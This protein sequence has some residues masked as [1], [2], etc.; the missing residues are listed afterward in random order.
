MR[1]KLLCV[2]LILVMALPV[3]A[4]APKHKQYLNPTSTRIDNEPRIDVN[5]ISMFVTNHGNYG[6]DLAG[7]FGLD[8]GTFF[9]YAGDEFIING[10]L[11]DWSM[12][13]MGMWAGGIIDG[14]IHLFINEYSDECVPGPTLDGYFQNDRAEFKVYKLYRD[15]L[16]GNPNADY[17]NWPVDQGAPLN[18][19]GEPDMIG[20][21]MLWAVYNDADTVQHDNDA[22][23]TDPLGYELRQTTFAF[24]RAG[25]LGNMIFVRFRIYNVGGNLVDPAYFSIWADPDL[26]D[27]GDDFVGCDTLTSMGYVYND[28]DDDSHYAPNPPAVGADFFQGPLVANTPADTADDGTP[29]FG[30]MWG[31]TIPGFHNLGMVSFSKY[32]NG[33]DPNSFGETYAFMQGQFKFEGLMTDYLIDG[34]PNEYMFPGDPV[35][36]E[37][38]LDFASA[39]RRWM[40]TTGPIA[41]APGDSTEILVAYIFGRGSSA[42]NSITVVRELDVF[43]QALYPEFTPPEPPAKPIVDVAELPGAITLTWTDA[44]QTN[45]GDY[46]FEGYSVWQGDAPVKGADWQLVATFDLVNGLTVLRDVLADPNSATGS[47]LEQTVR[48]GTDAGTAYSYTFTRNEL[49]GGD[50]FNFTEYFFKVSAF[51]YDGTAPDGDKFLESETIV[52]ATPRSEAAGVDYAHELGDMLEIAHS[53]GS[54]DGSVTAEIVDPSATTGQEYRVTFST[55]PTLGPVWHLTNVTTGA[56]ILAD[57]TNQTGDANYFAV[58]GM[59]VKVMGPAP[60]VKPGDMFASDDASTWGWDIVGTRRFTWGSA[61]GF[62]WEGFRG[63]LGW[64]GPGDV[65]GFGGAD[66]VDPALLPE[67]ELRLATVATDGTYDDTQEDVSFGYRYLRGA[68]NPAAQPEFAPFIID[69]TGSYTFQAFEKNVPLAAYNMDT[70]PPTR[71]VV[72]FLENNATNGLVDGQ[73]WPGTHDLY[74]NIDGGGPREWLW[75]YNDTYSEVGNPLY[76]LNAIDDPMPVMYW[77]TW[78]RHATSGQFFDDAD[79][80]IIFPNR[81]NSAADEYTFTS[82]APTTIMA[83][84]SLDDIKTVPNPFYLFGPYEADPRDKQVKFIN[85][86]DECTIKIFNLGGDLVRTLTHDENSLDPTSEIWS[87]LTTANVP[88]ASGIYIYVVDAPGFGQKIGKMAIF[89]EVEVLNRF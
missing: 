46:D 36:G 48:E 56:T 14:D 21:Q 31:D 18:E 16:A 55:D 8:A 81:V 75:I 41:F 40:Q 37:G 50:L 80:F 27:A 26:G 65:N 87:T 23:L 83:E 88:V 20:D 84:S 35:T 57:Q 69:P 33:S 79:I 44:S 24:D 49:G 30:L 62:G 72:G 77:A 61:D 45:P 34:I 12:Y 1:I 85:L 11:D 67:V 28:G 68:G 74:D 53:A 10:L 13:A 76:E 15:S 70:D 47:K 9:P 52:T 78:N 73:Y 32:I 4:A 2:L 58:D 82:N 38:D 89:T 43:A 7:V 29:L 6:R 71:L 42:L 3:M 86:P 19:F 17:L 25:A 5:N 51:S 22:G 63:A 54:A 66:P 59:L 60:G 64:G 39:D